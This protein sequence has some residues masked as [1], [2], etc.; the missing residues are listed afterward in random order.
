MKCIGWAHCA[1]PPS[2]IG[3]TFASFV[4][5]LKV[6]PPLSGGNKSRVATILLGLWSGGT[7]DGS[8]FVHPFVPGSCREV[9][10]VGGV[11]GP[12]RGPFC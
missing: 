1:P 9:A 4:V 11:L 7:V 8:P 6:S 3:L 5:C 10:V 2:E 12:C